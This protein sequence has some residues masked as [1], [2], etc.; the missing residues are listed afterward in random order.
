MGI[1]G[2][3]NNQSIHQKRLRL[4]LPEA[5]EEMLSFSCNI[6]VAYIRKIP[7]KERLI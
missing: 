3:S 7:Y 2:V 4:C 1:D 6:F 5:L